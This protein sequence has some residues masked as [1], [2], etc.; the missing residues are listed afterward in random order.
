[1]FSELGHDQR[2]FKSD[3]RAQACDSEA[4]DMLR[5][6]NSDDE[7]TADDAKERSKA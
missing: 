7:T 1:M 2:F 6:D 5:A 3:R 4:S